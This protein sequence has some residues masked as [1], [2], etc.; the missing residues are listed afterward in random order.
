VDDE[1]VSTADLLEQWRDATR[2][3]ELA[4][5][6]AKMAAESADRS[7]R[8]AAVAKEIA[9][10]AERAAK[11]ADRAAR[12]A[13]LA[14]ERAAGYA[15]ENRGNAL[16]DADGTLIEARSDEAAARERYHEAERTARERQGP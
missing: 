14:A 8:G 16:A 1:I 12:I 3:A 2:A 13:R 4:E 10:M 5:R 11:S 15:A 6:L 7:D 9:R